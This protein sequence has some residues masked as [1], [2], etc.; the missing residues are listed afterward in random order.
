MKIMCRV[1]PH[2]KGIMKIM[3]RVK[4]HGKGHYENYV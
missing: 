2:G 1:R 4:P 3:C